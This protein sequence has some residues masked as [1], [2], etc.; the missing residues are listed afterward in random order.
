MAINTNSVHTPQIQG[1]SANSSLYPP[2]IPTGVLPQ[3]KISYPILASELPRAPLLTADLQGELPAEEIPIYDPRSFRLPDFQ[4]RPYQ[5]SMTSGAPIFPDKKEFDTLKQCLKNYLGGF[6]PYK[7][8]K[9]HPIHDEL[10]KISQK[11]LTN[12]K[13]FLLARKISYLE[14][15]IAEL[16]I[17]CTYVPIELAVHIA[18]E[19]KFE[20]LEIALRNHLFQELLLEE[21]SAIEKFYHSNKKFPDHLGEKEGSLHS[22]LTKSNF[23][24]SLNLNMYSTLIEKI[25][26]PHLTSCVSKGVDNLPLTTAVQTNEKLVKK[27][28]ATLQLDKPSQCALQF[29]AI[30]RDQM[31]R[32]MISKSAAH[33]RTQFQ[34]T[35]SFDQDQ[36]VTDI[37][38]LQNFNT[39][40]GRI[41][42]LLN[43]KIQLIGETLE[44]P[45]PDNDPFTS[46]RNKII[47]EK[48]EQFQLT[49]APPPRSRLNFL[50][51][52]PF[53][54]SKT[55]EER[56]KEIQNLLSTQM[57]TINWAEREWN[58]MPN[59]L[60]S[61]RTE[62]SAPDEAP[63]INSFSDDGAPILQGDDMAHNLFNL[64]SYDDTTLFLPP[65][66]GALILPPPPEP[67]LNIIPVL[68]PPP[69]APKGI[70][71]PM[72]P[73]VV[74]HSSEFSA[75]DPNVPV[76]SYVDIAFKELLNQGRD[77]EK[78]NSLPQIVQRDVVRHVH[79]YPSLK[80]KAE[81]TARRI[82]KN[83]GWAIQKKCID[84]N[85][86]YMP[87]PATR[88]REDFVTAGQALL[89]FYYSDKIVGQFHNF[90]IQ[91]R[92]LPKDPPFYQY[93]YEMAK[94]AKVNI[95]S[96]DEHFAEYN[97]SQPGIL[98]LSV[99]ALERCLHTTPRN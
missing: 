37:E 57:T 41:Q 22:F 55:I 11:L 43:I 26:Q 50:K 93:V 63:E 91:F 27:Q 71:M 23:Y 87:T 67:V 39:S 40:N 47:Q 61:I 77:E 45:C 85:K 18:T 99:Q 12:C 97:W 82:F 81:E 75:L 86:V 38:K 46:I 60:T 58:T 80:G 25:V 5:F 29:E 92:Q 13:D 56:Q 68:L 34:K 30:L 62:P 32:K 16:T 17:G 7:I 73:I 84:L 21:K 66:D 64:N 79:Y 49:L 52:L 44:L 35:G 2:Q 53:L 24:Y 88:L 90:I 96:W 69:E 98:H 59:C 70:A 42:S 31:T 78:W 6:D 72:T 36:M 33:Y 51:A 14:N 28:L 95:P 48:E 4:L 9:A 10:I 1:L 20:L 65:D 3:N 15:A 94:A 54:S 89:D 19:P 8:N 76:L 83:D 74:I